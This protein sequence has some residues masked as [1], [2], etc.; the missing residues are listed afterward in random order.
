M[1]INFNFENLDEFVN[2]LGYISN[3][4][5]SKGDAVR[6]EGEKISVLRDGGEYF[7]FDNPEIKVEVMEIEGGGEGGSQ[8][9][10]TVFKV[11]ESQYFQ[12]NYSY[13]SY[14]GFSTEYAD[15]YEVVPREV[16]VTQ[17]EPK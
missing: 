16:L 5:A 4:G 8:D 11:G 3:W 14:D 9:C 12:V 10:Y 7:I 1:N 15:I 17:Y 2:V 6:C 13:Y